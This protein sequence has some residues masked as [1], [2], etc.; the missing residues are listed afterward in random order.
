MADQFKFGIVLKPRTLD[1]L[2]GANFVDDRRYHEYLADTLNEYWHR[3]GV[4]LL[5]NLLSMLVRVEGTY[6]TPFRIHEEA[7]MY[8]RISKIGRTSTVHEYQ[9]SEAT[10]GRLI[11]TFTETRVWVDIET[12]RPVAWPEDWKQKVIAFEGKENVNVT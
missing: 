12:H 5:P 2:M 4:K 10:S 11:A 7:Y 9:I 1:R 8:A 6:K 3:L